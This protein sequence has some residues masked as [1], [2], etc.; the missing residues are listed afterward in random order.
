MDHTDSPTL[1]MAL[2]VTAH[3]TVN[4]LVD[5]R[6]AVD[7]TDS[8]TLFMALLVTAHPTVNYLNLK[9]SRYH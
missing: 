5:L 6:W 2:L 7:H 4:Y 3:P 8:P 9:Q 1:F